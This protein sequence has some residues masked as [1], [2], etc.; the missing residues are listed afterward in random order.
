MFN[1]NLGMFEIISCSACFT[2]RKEYDVHIVELA[3]AKMKWVLLWKVSEIWEIEC[4]WTM[5]SN[6]KLLRTVNGTE[7]MLYDK[8]V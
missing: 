6:V 4:V 5:P 1:W 8:N 3:S 7:S 2:K